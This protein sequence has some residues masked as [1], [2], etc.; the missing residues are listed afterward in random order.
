MADI[1]SRFKLRRGTA[2]QWSVNPVLAAGEPGWET[3]T[4]KLRIGD[5][6]TPFLSLPYY[7][8]S[9]AFATTAQG[10]KADNALPAN[11][12]TAASDYQTIDT[13]KSGHFNAGP[14]AANRP[15]DETCA[16]RYHYIDATAGFLEATSITSGRR[17]IMRRSGSAWGSWV[18]MTR[19]TDVVQRVTGGYAGTADAL[20]DLAAGN[21]VH[22]LGAAA[23][24]FWSGASASDHVITLTTGAGASAQQIGFDKDGKVFYRGRSG[25]TWNTDGWKELISDVT[26]GAFVVPGAQINYESSGA[27]ASFPSG[28]YG[29]L[30]LNIIKNNSLGLT[31]TANQMTFTVAG[32]YY[33]EAIV[34]AR[35]A[36]GGG[37][38]AA[39]RLYNAT[40]VAAEVLG[41]GF[42]NANAGVAT[43]H[44]AG[45]FIVAANDLIELQGIA[46]GSGV[47]VGDE[48]DYNNP[49]VY[50]IVKL[51]K[52]S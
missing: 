39:V 26:I 23:T 4:K 35:N 22:L 42:N 27:P 2:A 36:S 46:S 52:V 41:T 43:C 12:S 37:R 45:R 20:G 6:V 21:Y 28:A 50:S 11:V 47:Q 48:T 1:P 31:L 30:P 24:G 3:D 14:A 49:N 19:T 17:F 10:T 8:D 29:A 33:I 25:A 9:T 5:G 44:I 34:T 51:W 7:D 16:I 13:S 15:L 18:E 32:T 38:S 40:A